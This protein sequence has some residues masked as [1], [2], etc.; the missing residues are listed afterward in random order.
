MLG[1]S[2]VHTLSFLTRQVP[3]F[4]D[5]PWLEREVAGSY[6]LFAYARRLLRI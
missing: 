3:V 5:A 1:A 2:V 4:Q 6:I